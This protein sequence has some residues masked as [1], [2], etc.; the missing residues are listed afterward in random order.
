MTIERVYDLG[1]GRLAVTAERGDL[2]DGFEHFLGERRLDAVSPPSVSVAIRTGAPPLPPPSA[3][4]LYS[5][6]LLEEGECL[7]ARRDDTYFMTFPGEASLT[8]DIVA[9]HAEMIVSPS[10]P[11][12]ASGGLAAIAIEFAYDN[13]G[14]QLLHAAGLALPRQAG[15]ILIS[16][17]SGTGKT[18][19][20]LALARCGLAFAADDVV[21]LR[22]DGSR[23]M[24][25]GLP[26]AL[27]VHRGTLA[28][29]PWIP[30]EGEWRG[31]GEQS[32]PVRRLAEAVVMEDRELPVS[33]LV[34]LRRG[35]V[36]GVEPLSA[37]EMLVALA[38]DNVRGSL[39]GLTPLQSRRFAM[40]AEMTRTVPACCV[41]LGDG[42][43]GI[44]T[45]AEALK[46]DLTGRETDSPEVKA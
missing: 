11:G 19:T 29:L 44:E 16:A 10:R 36:S 23:I 27:N 30:L 40:L 38:T 37:A 12:R 32:L 34:L 18:T 20:A 17:P 25:R 24:A 45:V 31:N 7:F 26:R 2:L 39:A 3:E 46:S 41:T 43:A 22:R 13:G 35:A 42:L 28:L 1:M 6:P 15:M 33:R 14:Q 9:G 5:G 4:T 21:A 8:M